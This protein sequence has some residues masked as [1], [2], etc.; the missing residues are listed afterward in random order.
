MSGNYVFL[1]SNLLTSKSRT[2]KNIASSAPHAELQEIFNTTKELLYLRGFVA[3]LGITLA[4][5]P[6]ILTDSLSSV[7]TLNRPVSPAYKFISIMIHFLKEK[8]DQKKIQVNY[9]S[10]E[11]NMA[12]ILTKQPTKKEFIRLW[13]MVKSPFQWKREIV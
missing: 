3:E 6:C 12:D 1:G 2:Q 5:P 9:I 11:F 8:V 13:D 7:N 10:R 4:E